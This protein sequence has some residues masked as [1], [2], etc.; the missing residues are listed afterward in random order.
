MKKMKI[1]EKKCLK[2]LVVSFFCTT[3][4]GV[5][6]GGNKYVPRKKN[7]IILFKCCIYENNFVPLHY[8][9]KQTNINP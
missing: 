9:I 7:K 1:F 6:K 4:V 2:N 5:K 3:F 8:L